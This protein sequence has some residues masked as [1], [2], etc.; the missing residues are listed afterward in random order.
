M[1]HLFLANAWR[2]MVSLT[3]LRANGE[4]DLKANNRLSPLLIG[5]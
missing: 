1:P 2:D 3:S 5:L 4:V